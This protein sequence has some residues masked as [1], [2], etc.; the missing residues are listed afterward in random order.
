MTRQGTHKA[1]SILKAVLPL[2]YHHHQWA[3]SREDSERWHGQPTLLVLGLG[4]CSISKQAAPPLL[5]F[6]CGEPP[7]LLALP[8]ELPDVDVLFGAFA[9]HGIRDR[10]LG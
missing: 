10:N 9:L 3:E 7:S 6:F 4:D 8:L 5:D 2:H 1:S